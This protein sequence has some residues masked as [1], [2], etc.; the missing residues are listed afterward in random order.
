MSIILVSCDYFYSFSFRGDDEKN[1]IGVELIN[2]DSP[3]TI[4][5][6]LAE[7][8][9]DKNKLQI[10]EAL[11]ADKIEA[12][13]KKLY[14]IGVNGGKYEQVLYSHHGVGLRIIYE[15]E[16]FKIITLSEIQDKEYFFV[17]EYDSMENRKE[18]KSIDIPSMAESF[19]E[20]LGEYFNL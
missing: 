6:P 14:G 3:D 2:Y 9:F 7:Y 18:T 19:K 10:L 15:D 5:N 4:A 13:L 11:D 1:I 8:M 17:A 12:F 16:G 20:L